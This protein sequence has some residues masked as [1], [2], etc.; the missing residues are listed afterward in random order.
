MET[1]NIAGEDN[2][3]ITPLHKNI[4]YIKIKDEDYDFKKAKL[5]SR[6]HVSFRIGPA[7][8]AGELK[9]SREN[10]DYLKQ[11]LLQHIIPNLIQ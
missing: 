9:A 8:I 11:I 7:Q 2:F 6:C 10:C 5:T 4:V 3:D 1:K